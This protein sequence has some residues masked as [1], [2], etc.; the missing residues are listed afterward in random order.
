MSLYLLSITNV[1]FAMRRKHIE[2]TKEKL[3]AKFFKQYSNKDGVPNVPQNEKLIDGISERFSEGEGDD[4]L[5]SFKLEPAHRRT[6]LSNVMKS[7]YTDSDVLEK[8]G[9]DLNTPARVRSESL[10]SWTSDH[11]TVYNDLNQLNRLR[12]NVSI[13]ARLNH[14]IAKDIVRTIC[15]GES[16]EVFLSTDE[17]IRCSNKWGIPS[18]AHE[19]FQVAAIK[20]VM[21]AGKK[22]IE[23][24]G[25]KVINEV[26]SIELNNFYAPLLLAMNVS[27]TFLIQWLRNADDLATNST[28]IKNGSEE[29]KSVQ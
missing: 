24:D 13:H 6:S 27:D 4:T 19:A 25:E 20:I 17:F 11:N 7:L 16:G 22:H 8:K 21:M 2:R 5:Q 12:V 14:I 15:L 26:D 23:I 18:V 1:Y 9:D 10:E 3:Q 28:Y 29:T